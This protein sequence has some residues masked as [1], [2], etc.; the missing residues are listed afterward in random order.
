MPY[1]PGCTSMREILDG[2]LQTAQEALRMWT[3]D[4]LAEEE[5][6]PAPRSRSLDEIARDPQVAEALRHGAAFA[7]VPLLIETGRSAKANLSMGALSLAAI[8]DAAAARGLTRSAVLSSAAREKNLQRRAEFHKRSSLDL[9][10]LSSGQ[11]STLTMEI[12]Q[13][14]GNPSLQFVPPTTA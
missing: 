6:L 9:S 13:Q 1:M 12:V 11:T 7:I 10:V 4:A 5:R 2:L 3:E 8:D 14:M